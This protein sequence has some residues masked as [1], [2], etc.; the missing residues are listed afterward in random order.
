MGADII[1]RALKGQLTILVGVGE[2]RVVEG[3]R[4][5]W[6]R[7]VVLMSRA[8]G[9]I[10]GVAEAVAIE[11]SGDEDDDVKRKALEAV[12][13]VV[14]PERTIG[15]RGRAASIGWLYRK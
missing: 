14:I 13:A 3:C 4:L 9:M 10:L 2:A 8:A 7:A 1:C 5:R 6:L 15:E 12:V 11:R